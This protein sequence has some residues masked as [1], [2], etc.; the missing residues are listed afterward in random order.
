MFPRNPLDR[1][2]VEGVCNFH[3]QQISFTVFQVI[4]FL[5]LANEIFNDEFLCFKDGYMSSPERGT[6]AYEEPYYTQYG[7]RGSSVTPIIDEEQR[8]IK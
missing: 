2:E 1:M 3:T 8:L 4:N 5:L 6:R 7:T